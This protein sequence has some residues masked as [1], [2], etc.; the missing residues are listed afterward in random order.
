MIGFRYFLD[1]AALLR[2][3][4]EGKRKDAR[5]VSRAHQY[6]IRHIFESGSHASSTHLK[7]YNP[8]AYRYV[9]WQYYVGL[10]H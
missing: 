10:L 5:A 8:K 1:L 3:L 6:F 4:T 9:P 7:K 2:F